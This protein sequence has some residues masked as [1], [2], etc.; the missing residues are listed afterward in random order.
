MAAAAAGA[1]VLQINWLLPHPVIA[2]GISSVCTL[3]VVGAVAGQ[4]VYWIRVTLATSLYLRGVTYTNP[5]WPNP[6]RSPGPEAIVRALQ[7]QARLGLLILGLVMLPATYLL[8]GNSRQRTAVDVFVI[9]V[10]A[11]G[12][13][14]V[15]VGVVAVGWIQ[16]P[17]RRIANKVLADAGTHAREGWVKVQGLS[18]T[19]KASKEALE[20]YHRELET[21]LLLEGLA[22][23]GNGARNT[24]KLLLASLPLFVQVAVIVGKALS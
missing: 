14:I 2:S 3:I 11:A 13:V 22:D 4:A 12:A 5:S 16:E 10:G 1:L 17:L 9:F 23:S 18:C 19:S 20:N 15:T 7:G 24:S 8:L 6:Y 21:L